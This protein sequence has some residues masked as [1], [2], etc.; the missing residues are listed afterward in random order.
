MDHFCYKLI[1]RF[2]LSRVSDKSTAGYKS[3]VTFRSLCD[4][5]YSAE[6]RSYSDECQMNPYLAVKLSFTFRLLCDVSYSHECQKKKG[7]FTI[8]ETVFNFSRD[9]EILQYQQSKG[10]LSHKNS[11]HENF[12]LNR[13][14][15]ATK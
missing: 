14:M 10:I 3:N 4:V 15:H 7:T 6:C 12:C 5:S 8:L 11:K 13:K 9:D 1:R 2:V